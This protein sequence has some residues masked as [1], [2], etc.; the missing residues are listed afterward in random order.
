MFL[1]QWLQP[2][3]LHQDFNFCFPDFCKP[4]SDWLPSYT[5]SCCSL[6]SRLSTCAVVVLVPNPCQPWTS[7]VQLCFWNACLFA[8]VS[9]NLWTLS[10]GAHFFCCNW[11]HTQLVRVRSVQTWTQQHLRLHRI[12]L[13]ELK[14][15]PINTDN[16]LRR[17]LHMLDFL[18]KPKPDAFT[19]LFAQLQQL[20]P[21]HP[22]S[23]TVPTLESSGSI[24]PKPKIISVPWV[25]TPEWYDGNTKLHRPC[26]TRSLLLS[27]QPYR[28]T[29]KEASVWHVI[30]NL[31][32]KA[33]RVGIEVG[34]RLTPT[35]PSFSAC[36]ST[37][38]KVFSFETSD[39]D[40]TLNLL[41]LCQE[42]HPVV[43]FYIDCHSIWNN[44]ALND[45]SLH[46]LA[47]CLL[48]PVKRQD[49]T[50]CEGVFMSSKFS[51]LS[52]QFCSPLRRSSARL[53]SSSFRCPR[54]SPCLRSGQPE[55]FC[56]VSL[57]VILLP[58]FP[59]PKP[60]SPSFSASW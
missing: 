39:S 34:D 48:L 4:I 11:V 59:A 35:C 40:A 57:S 38:A 3:V 19:S 54:H 44:V 7:C 50:R 21:T 53:Q 6:L 13:R 52:F 23:F 9:V 55:F 27:L 1:L 51:S 16:Q 32:S 46:A 15:C 45:D 25:G 28:F 14:I 24:P 18:Q 60:D 36:P 2:S 56:H 37:K 33:L 49:S 42:N 26:L 43:H 10:F 8:W 58:D 17:L 47:F 41:S 31:T 20:M 30:S 29:P 12:S 5:F 22:L